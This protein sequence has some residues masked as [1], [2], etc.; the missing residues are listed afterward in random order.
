MKI[1][2]LSLALAGWIAQAD[3]QESR[4]EVVKPTTAF[5]DSRMNDDSIPA[6]TAIGSVFERVVI[7]R[8]KYKA[9]LLRGLEQCVREEKIS[10]AVILSGIG[11]VRSY[12]YH[13]VVNR[14]FP[15]KT[16]YV[17]DTAGSADIVNVN[18]YVINGRVHAH[19]TLANAEKAFGGHLEDGTEVFTFAVVT[20]GVLSDQ[21]DLRRI[22]DKT[23][24]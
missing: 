12:H 4:I 5:H 11:S 9:D 24:R 2:I 23:Y 18:G 3:A 16:V 17:K 19:V 7:V 15:S 20:L 13:A 8:Q 10:N 22:D 6:V 14:T 21:L 1:L